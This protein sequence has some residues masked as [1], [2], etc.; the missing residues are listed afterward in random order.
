MK[1][2]KKQQLNAVVKLLPSTGVRELLQ[3]QPGAAPA[4]ALSCAA[5]TQLTH[6]TAEG[7]HPAPDPACSQTQGTTTAS[8]Q[9]Q[10][11]ARWTQCLVL[12]YARSKATAAEHD[13]KHGLS[14]LFAF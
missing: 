12:K 3:E 6:G 14:S 10:L 5:V 13:Y 4:A 7:T 1:L 11:V 8:A 9:S 2:Q